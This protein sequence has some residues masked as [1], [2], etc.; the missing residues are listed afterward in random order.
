MTETHGPTNDASPPMN[1][2]PRLHWNLPL[3]DQID[4]LDGRGRDG[5]RNRATS[6]MA[7]ASIKAS[8]EGMRNRVLGSIRDLGEHGASCDDVEIVLDMTH[9]TASARMHE[10]AWAGFIHDS[11]ELEIDSGWSDRQV[12]RAP[13][14]LKDGGQGTAGSRAWR[15]ARRTTSTCPCSS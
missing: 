14:R 9:Q 15:L 4:V 2:P 13:E 8:A 12:L 7:A 5:R 6:R 1:T 11:E 3:P 10:L